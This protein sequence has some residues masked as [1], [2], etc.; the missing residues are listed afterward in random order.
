MSFLT[1]A[2]Q[3][4]LMEFVA[5]N[6]ENYEAYRHY[7]ES[8]GWQLFS[9]Q[10]LRNWVQRRRAAV[11][12]LRE[13][14]KIEVRKK[15]L[16]DRE[17]RIA[18]LEDGVRRIAS[19]LQ[20]EDG[21]MTTESVV[22]LLDQQRKHLQAIAQERGEWGQRAESDDA[23]GSLEYVMKMLAN[24]VPALQEPEQGVVIDAD[25]VRVLAPVEAGT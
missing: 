1:K 2:A 6:G 5:A 10:Y 16:L 17:A 4:D 18:Y 22:K 24:R 8:R 15:S 12:A 11:Q 13:I 3:R 7:A 19:A 20:S 21:A 23:P 25:G 9:P 14:H